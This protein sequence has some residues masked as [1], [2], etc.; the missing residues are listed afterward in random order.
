[1]LKDTDESDVK[2]VADMFIPFVKSGSKG[3]R[4]LVESGHEGV[5]SE[6]S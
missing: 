2:M 6:R 4:V 3:V 5:R 1:M